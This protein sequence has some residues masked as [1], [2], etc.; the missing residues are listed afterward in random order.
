VCH[1]YCSIRK[2]DFHPMFS[3]R[4]RKC[5][6]LQLGAACTYCTERGLRCTRDSSF[7]S[8]SSSTP[9][10]RSAKSKSA[11]NDAAVREL[12]PSTSY[13]DSQRL[14]QPPEDVPSRELCVELVHLYFDF[15]HDQFHTLFHRPTFVEDVENDRAPPVITFAMMALSAR[16]DYL[17]IL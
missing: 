11:P 14:D 16:S 3:S 6:A 9:Q 1:F 10:A 5:E 12:A 7:L 8:S 4:R 15:I 2:T 13:V 17:L